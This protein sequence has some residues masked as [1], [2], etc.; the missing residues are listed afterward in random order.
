MNDAVIDET[1]RN[2]L[3]ECK[4]AGVQDWRDWE[5]RLLSEASR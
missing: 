3:E 5:K 1:L 4:R 2:I